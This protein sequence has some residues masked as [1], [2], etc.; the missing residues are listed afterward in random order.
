MLLTG[1]TIFSFVNKTP[2]NQKVAN[3]ADKLKI[4]NV[5]AMEN[6]NAGQVKEVR[7]ADKDDYFFNKVGGNHQ[8]I[9]Y[10]D[11]DCP[12][13]RQY[14]QVL[15]QVKETFGQNL[16]I[17]W[18]H[19]PLASHPNAL[20]AAQAF[21]CAREQGQA[22]ALAEA[23]FDNQN[24]ND[25]NIEGILVD[26]QGLGLSLEDF[27]RCLISEKYKAKILAQKEEAELFGVNGTP[28]SFLNG[29]N[30]PG[31][32]QFT[33]FSDITGRQHEGLKTLIEKELVK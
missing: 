9:V 13:C 5:R 27:K 29:R 10:W 31:A 12:F 6:L 28:T 4:A 2:S 30:L 32:Y 20:L 3:E 24:K 33:D 7:W 26:A 19:F 14:Y 17:V 11:F 21:E 23:L 25:N 22:E 18:R 15:K 1:V 16:N 8:L